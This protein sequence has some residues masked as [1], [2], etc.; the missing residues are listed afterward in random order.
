MVGLDWSTWERRFWELKERSI[1][2]DETAYTLLLHGYVLSHRHQS[3]N[4]YLVL[5]EM[6]KAETHPALVR[7]NERM[8]NS[9]FELQELGLRPEAAL[10]QNVVRL[11]F[12][13]SVR[14]QKKRRK[15]LKQELKE[16]EPDDAL[17]LDEDNIRHWLRGHDRLTLPEGG[18]GR[19][20]PIPGPELQHLSPWEEQKL[21]SNWVE[22]PLSWIAGVFVASVGRSHRC[23]ESWRM[24]LLGCVSELS[25]DLL[26][27]LCLFD[28][29]TP[30]FLAQIR[31]YEQLPS[32]CRES[33]RSFL[34]PGV[35]KLSLAIIEEEDGP[36]DP[37]PQDEVIY[38]A[39]SLADVIQLQREF[40]QLKSFEVHWLAADLTNASLAAGLLLYKGADHGDEDA[41]SR[42]ELEP[43]EICAFAE[44]RLKDVKRVFGEETLSCEAAEVLRLKALALEIRDKDDGSAVFIFL[45][46]LELRIRDFE[47]GCFK[48]SQVERRLERCLDDVE[49]QLELEAV[50]EAGL[51]DEVLAARLVEQRRVIKL[52]QEELDQLHFEHQVLAEE[53]SRLRE[54]VAALEPEEMSEEEEF[55]VGFSTSEVEAGGDTRPTSP[56]MRSPGRSEELQGRRASGRSHSGSARR[57]GVSS[58]SDK[59]RS[60]RMAGTRLRSLL[61]VAALVLGVTKLTSFRG[62]FSAPPRNP[63]S[64]GLT[65]RG[66]QPAKGAVI[67]VEPKAEAETK[68]V[69]ESTALNKTEEVAQKEKRERVVAKTA[70]T[71]KRVEEKKKRLQSQA[72]SST[73]SA[74]SE[75]PLIDFKGLAAQ[76]I[77]MSE[78]AQK[79]A[80][81]K[82]NEL[83]VFAAEAKE[84]FFGL[85][86]VGL[87]AIS[88]VPPLILASAGAA[89]LVLILLLGSAKPG[90]VESR[91]SPV[92]SAPTIV[93]VKPPVVPAASVVETPTQ[94][95]KPSL[96][97]AVAPKSTPSPLGR[98]L[99]NS[100]ANVLRSIADGLPVAEQAAE[101]GVPVVESAFQWA[102]SLNSNNAEQKV[103]N[104][105]LPVVGKAAEG[106]IRLGLQVGSGG[107]DLIGKTLPA[108]EEALGK[109]V[110]TG[111]P[112]AQSAL[113]DAAS[114]A[115]RVAAE[116]I[117][118]G[119]SNPYLQGVASNMPLILNATAG[120]LDATADMAPTVKSAVGYVAN[121]ATPVAQA[122]LSTASD[123]ARDAS[124]IPS[125]TVEGGATKLLEAA[126]AAPSLA[127]SARQALSAAV[128]KV[129]T[130]Q[131]TSVASAASV[132]SVASASDL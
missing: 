73:E 87:E 37:Q 79:E 31:R 82:N 85:A 33:L 44:K 27:S 78:E 64:R 115:R 8:L 2:Y 120:A 66:A 42:L 126:K 99:A 88:G 110:D 19:F 30:K 105:L 20:R 90:N 67:E 93:S 34:A 59:N 89:T 10:W 9:V 114:N 109:A 1:P 81:S 41:I 32:W 86:A 47:E 92:T 108:A 4:A 124:N 38:V 125:S 84:T 54:E 97:P 111:L 21:L 98:S 53:A 22:R 3:E 100:A 16:L 103:E 130:T 18:L 70:E 43:E 91:P 112:L 116:G 36:I 128:A 129:P 123:L 83:E 65:G 132:A 113:H 58:S 127:D 122:V 95:V 39:Q 14:F 76:S 69:V 51:V 77:K 28:I 96:P 35:P 101:D 68:P 72:E 106:A 6:K 118:F 29:L 48:L 26:E 12:H 45:D 5:D 24:K 63:N 7:L 60:N 74:Q 23:P 49:S 57:Q 71:K 119:D 62:A 15:R 80:K 121:A 40:L 55:A 52:Q 17:A 50:Q 104:D 75:E 13:C 11:C 117:S 56:P 61:I 46:G 102:S 94:E 107:L 25:K 131:A